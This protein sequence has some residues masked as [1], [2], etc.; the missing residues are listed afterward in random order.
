VLG[1]PMP[2]LEQILHLNAPAWPILSDQELE[3]KIVPYRDGYG[4]YDITIESK[5]YKS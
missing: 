2:K 4:V 3:G 5:K 1:E